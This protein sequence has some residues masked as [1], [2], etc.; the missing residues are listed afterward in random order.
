MSRFPPSPSIQASC[1]VGAGVRGIYSPLDFFCMKGWGGS[2]TPS[3]DKDPRP[4]LRSISGVGPGGAPEV[5]THTLQAAVARG[6]TLRQI[7]LLFERPALARPPARRRPLGR[8]PRQSQGRVPSWK[9]ACHALTRSFFITKI[10]RGS[11]HLKMGRAPRR[12]QHLLPV[13]ETCLH[14]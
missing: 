6:F 10:R 3:P 8:L 9:H 1:G 4:P 5:A 2:G 11:V 13:P 14:L 12:S 7:G